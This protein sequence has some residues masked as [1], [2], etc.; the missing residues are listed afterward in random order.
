LKVIDALVYDRNDVGRLATKPQGSEGRE[1]FNV[2]EE[3]VDLLAVSLQFHIG[4]G[5]VHHNRAKISALFGRAGKKAIKMY[6][7]YTPGADF[8]FFDI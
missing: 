4:R 7:M 2:I 1:L 6:K 5:D 8:S 3:F